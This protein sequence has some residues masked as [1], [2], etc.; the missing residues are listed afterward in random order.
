[1]LE[2]LLR[3]QNV[4]PAN[5]SREIATSRNLKSFFFP[6]ITCMSG[7]QNA[8]GKGGDARAVNG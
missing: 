7:S 4:T 3:S 5:G 8:A 2:R 6:E 1:M